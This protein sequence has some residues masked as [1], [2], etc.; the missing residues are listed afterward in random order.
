MT[1]LD[2]QFYVFRIDEEACEY[3][4]TLTKSFKV[5]IY[6]TTHFRPIKSIVT[7]IEHMLKENH[8]PKIDIDLANVFK[9]LGSREK[10]G[11]EFTP[12]NMNEIIKKITTYEKSKL[13]KLISRDQ[14]LFNREM[15]TILNFL[16]NL[17]IK[18]IVTPVKSISNFIQDDLRGVNP[19]FL[20]TVGDQ[21]E[22]LDFE[23]K[24]VNNVPIGSKKAWLLPIA[25]IFIVGLIGI[26]LYMGY[27]Q[28]AFESISVMIPDISEVSLMPDTQPPSGSILDQYPTPAAAKAAIDAGEVSITEFP[29]D[30]RD[31]IMKIKVEVSP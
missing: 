9:L 8:L 4:Q 13:S 15:E 6:D 17:G 31:N 11:E 19:G 10:D 1:K 18:K 14:N 21:L 24:K 12:H 20:G 29:I 26:V 27:E 25:L 30:M 22:S 23:N 3:R 2:N 7:E 5:Y 16:D 28:G